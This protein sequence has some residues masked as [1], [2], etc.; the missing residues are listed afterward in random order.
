MDRA[1]VLA[2]SVAG[3]RAGSWLAERGVAVRWLGLGPLPVPTP[4]PP[5]LRGR[6][7]ELE[8]LVGGVSEVRPVRA[9][10]VDGALHDVPRRRRD[11]LRLGGPPGPADLVR[12][13]LARLGRAD[14]LEGWCAAHLGPVFTR[15]IALPYAAS[16]LGGPAGLLAAGQGSALFGRED[17]GWQ[18]PEA[19]PEA[20]AEGRREAMLDAGGEVLE[21]V[22]VGS[23]EVDEGGVV[24]VHTEFGRELVDELV[25]V[26]LEPAR[27]LS[28]LPAEAVPAGLHRELARLPAAGEVVVELHGAASALPWVVHVADAARPGF[29]VFRPADAPGVPSPHRVQVQLAALADDPVW[30]DDSAAGAAALR[31]V[32]G[33][34]DDATVHRIERS[35]GA[36]IRCAPAAEAALDRALQAWGPLG[37]V[38]VGPRALHAPLDL[39]DEAT[40]LTLVTSGTS[41]QQARRTLLKPGARGHPWTLVPD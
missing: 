22:E 11:L 3:L 29:R 16:R 36:L 19:D 26:D 12:W 24:A 2:S 9:L 21:D 7:A 41:P 40:W 34:V 20:W 37:L 27:L 5:A 18:A 13:A 15:R 35:A 8:P 4:W 10:L 30:L 33:L 38:P 28:L 14:S 17:A 6:P 39:E 32:R 25:F 1:V 31:T 23:F